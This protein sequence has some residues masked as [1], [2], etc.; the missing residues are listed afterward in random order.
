MTPAAGLKLEP[1]PFCG[2]EPILRDGTGKRAP[3]FDVI[4]VSKHPDGNP[5]QA[6]VWPRK[7]ADEAISAWNTRVSPLEDDSEYHRLCNQ[8]WGALGVSKYT[9][10]SIP[11]H[12]LELRASLSAPAEGWVLVPEP[13]TSE[14]IRAMHEA[15]KSLSGVIAG[16]NSE[17]LHYRSAVE[18]QYAKDVVARYIAAAPKKGGA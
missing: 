11:E 12:I 5:C 7:T 18:F 17:W 3:P 16:N 15:A 13:G 10:K 6:M 14:G 9:G 8:C 2:S 4:C 1:C